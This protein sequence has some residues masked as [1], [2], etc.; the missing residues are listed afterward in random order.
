MACFEV[1]FWKGW[2]LLVPEDD[3]V[4]HVCYFS[5]LSNGHPDGGIVNWRAEVERKFVSPP[6][7]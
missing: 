7:G 6:P 4:R 2:R 5:V 3:F 1:G